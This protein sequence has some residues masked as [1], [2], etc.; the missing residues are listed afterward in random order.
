MRFK[1]KEEFAVFARNFIF[2][3]ED[4]LV[5]TVG[6]LSGVAVGGMS[7]S[8]I[9]LTGVV[10]IFVEAFS[11]G[12]GSFLSEYSADEY[13]HRKKKIMAESVGGSIIM[14]ITYIIAGLIPLMPYVL[15]KD[16]TAFGWSIALSLLALL[17]LG[18]IS[19][20]LLKIPLVKSGIRMLVIG[21][22]AVGVG[23]VVAN[24]VH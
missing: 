22:M 15:V 3:T 5:S 11:M 2:G 13:L 4:S 1:D 7:R 6:L 12:V 19:G 24:I 18:L 14:F 23:V 20:K 16:Q 10:L 21:G 9:L 8:D 17:I